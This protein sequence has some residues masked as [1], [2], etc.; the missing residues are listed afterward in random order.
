MNRKSKQRLKSK[1]VKL[2]NIRYEGE[3]VNIEYQS[4][5][6]VGNSLEVSQHVRRT[7]EHSGGVCD[8]PAD[9]LSKGMSGTLK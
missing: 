3:K 4:W 6:T 5:I 7:E 1:N 2:K 9:S 8:I